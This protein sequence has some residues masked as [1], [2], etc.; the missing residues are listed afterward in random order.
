MT[1]RRDFLTSVSA[2]ATGMLALPTL[3]HAARVQDIGL[4][5]YSVRDDM[6]RDA[7]GTLSSLAKMGYKEIESANSAKGYY[8]GL[9]PK[10]MKQLMGSLGMTLRS[11][12]VG[13]DNNW[14]KAV[15]AAAEAGQQYL[16][17]PSLPTQGQTVSNYERCADTFNKAAEACRKAG[18]QFAYHN[19]NSEFEKDNGKVL[20]DVLLE[21]TDPRLVSMEMD[22]GWVVV[23]GYDPFQYFERYPNRFPLWHLKDMKKGEAH[24]TVLGTGR[25][26]VAKLLRSAKKSGMKYF[27]VEQEEY[28]GAPL[29]S[30]Q[31]N[32][33]YLKGLNY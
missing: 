24:S 27:F 1:T 13:I 16:V 28:E 23:A 2:L 29:A 25:L 19:H 15:D 12:H 3:A 7:K 30:M 14:Q 32:I 4:Q 5:L 20:Y 22:L 26:D 31:R 8:Y 33:A 11:G 17:C 21:K 6:M 9:S 18:V 10:E